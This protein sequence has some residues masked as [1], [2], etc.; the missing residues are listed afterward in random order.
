MRIDSDS[1]FKEVNTYLPNLFH[2]QLYYH[3]QYVGVEDGVDFLTGLFDFAVNHMKDTQ[4]PP[5]PRNYLLW[6]MSQKVWNNENTLPLFRSNFEVS[7]KSFM[8]R[9][10]VVKWHEALTE[11]EPF[12]VFR[13]RWG[14]AVT[15]FLMASI[16]ENMERFLTVKPTGYFHKIGCSKEEVEEALRTKL[17]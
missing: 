9:S 7:K 8:Q 14:D 3:S 11:R 13:Y 15:R 2:D 17:S 5:E 1:C 6:D 10:D 4:D 12:G 16:F